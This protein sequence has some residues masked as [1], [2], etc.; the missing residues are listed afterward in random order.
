MRP[1]CLFV[2]YFASAPKNANPIPQQ[3]P[4]VTAIAAIPI[5]IFAQ[6]GFTLLIKKSPVQLRTALTAPPIAPPATGR[7]S[8]SANVLPQNHDE[9]KGK[10]A[11]YDFVPLDFAVKRT[12][13]PL[14]KRHAPYK[15]FPFIVPIPPSGI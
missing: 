1:F 2:Y 6:T 13:S 14:I 3:I 4:N 8:Q 11:K 7:I 9:K 15:K 5:R 10:K 12:V